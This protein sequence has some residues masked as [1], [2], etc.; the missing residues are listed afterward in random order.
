VPWS[1][2]D[3]AGL[4][5][6]LEMTP[7]VKGHLYNMAV[8]AYSGGFRSFRHKFT[9]ATRGSDGQRSLLRFKFFKTA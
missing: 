5:K 9:M 7:W 8:R 2:L 3:G 6:R 1:Q 4:F